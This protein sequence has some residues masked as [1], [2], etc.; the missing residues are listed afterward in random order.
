MREFWVRA[1]GKFTTFLLTYVPFVASVLTASEATKNY[2]NLPE[3]NI[4]Y[5]V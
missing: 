3:E 5:F 4:A 2:P 1:K